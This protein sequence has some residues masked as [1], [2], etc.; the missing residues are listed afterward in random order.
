ML[1]SKIVSQIEDIRDSVL[2]GVLHCKGH[3]LFKHVLSFEELQNALRWKRR[4]QDVDDIVMVTRF[5]DEDSARNLIADTLL[6]N[7]EG[8]EK[9]LLSSI[10]NDYVATATFDSPTGDGLAKNTDFTKTIPVHGVTV[11]LRKD[12]SFVGQS[13]FVV[14]AYPMRTLDDVDVIYEVIDEY[15]ARKGV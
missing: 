11:V 7:I 3:A 2:F 1:K 12:F 15:I 14:T 8:I 5:F 13:F 10:D 4:A 6:L 9:W